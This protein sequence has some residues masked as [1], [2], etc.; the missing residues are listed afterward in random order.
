[1]RTAKY[2]ARDNMLY[3]NAPLSLSTEI[4]WPTELRP[5]G[6]S[7]LTIEKGTDNTGVGLRLQR[8]RD[9]VNELR[10]RQGK[11]NAADLELN[12]TAPG[13][14]ADTYSIKGAVVLHVPS[15][16]SSIR[17]P[18]IKSLVG[19][20]I[21]VPGLEAFSL[22][23][24]SFS[25]SNLQ[26]TSDK[27]TDAIIDFKLTSPDLTKVKKKFHL[28]RSKFRDEHRTQVGFMSGGGTK[29]ENPTLIIVVAGE[30]GKYAVPFEFKALKMP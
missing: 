12:I 19:K 25:G 8:Q 17:V 11:E 21:N 24:K 20:P 3:G 28:Y 26:L 2:D 29:I 7:H 23:L 15:S 30:V 16:I 22:K 13:R 10:P 27:P 18:D 4:S 14:N 1:M 9:K 6:W 5:S